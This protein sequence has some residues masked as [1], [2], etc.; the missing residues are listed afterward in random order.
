M[1][2][3]GTPEN[4][5]PYQNNKQKDVQ[6]EQMFDKIAGRYDLLNHILSLGFDRSWRRKCIDYFKPFAPDTMLDIA[7]GTGDLAI[8]AC[9]RLKPHHVIAADL[10]RGM[11]NIGRRKVSKAGFSGCISFEYQNCMSLSYRNDSF[12]GVTAAFGVRNFSHIKQGLAE[13]YRVLKPGGHLA[14]LE[15]SVPAC[16][17]A[18][19]LY[20]LYAKVMVS[21][22]G[23]ILGL[24]KAAYHYLP[25][26]VK[27]M[28]QGKEMV[29][30][31]TEQGFRKAEAGRFTWGVCSMY[32]AMK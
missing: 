15:L 32:T 5:R 30:L 20:H 26:S 16:F 11:M 4:I 21:Y 12:D 10:S 8:L 28:P 14:I 1:Y 22:A 9:K 7:S 24:E 2:M 23:G 6:I 19:Q 27:A 25:E 29:D 17:P 18:K 13:M 3:S 31:L